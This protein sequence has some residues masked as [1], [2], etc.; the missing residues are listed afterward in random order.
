MCRAEAVAVP[1]CV[2][3]DVANLAGGHRNEAQVGQELTPEGDARS[4]AARDR[5]SLSM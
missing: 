2:H 1:K 5:R 3:D 4:G